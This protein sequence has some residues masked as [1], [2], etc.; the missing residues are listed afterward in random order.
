MLVP[1]MVLAAL[2]VMAGCLAPAVLL[3]IRP[4]V[5]VL[6]GDVS[7]T[8]LNAT[9]QAVGVLWHVTFGACLL[10]VPVAG[11]TWLRRRLLK[12]RSVSSTVTWDCGYAAPTPRM[13]YTG[14]SYVQPLAE[15]FHAILRT[16]RV[17]ELTGVY[18]PR[19]G[20]LTTTSPDTVHL[21]LYRPLFRALV[22]GMGRFRKL[23][24]GNLHLYVLY[25]AIALLALLIWKV[26]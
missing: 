10:L 26:G 7:T 1:Q 19:G 5:A 14:S 8:V 11:L 4:A 18:F 22:G 3:A 21:R 16:R 20:H 24:H 12:G 6:A 13:S 23:Q 15:V 17:F 9:T 25:I 2:C